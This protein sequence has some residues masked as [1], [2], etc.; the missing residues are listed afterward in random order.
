MIY[1]NIIY[2]VYYKQW[3]ASHLT[4]PVIFDPIPG[5]HF[6]CLLIIILIFTD[7]VICVSIINNRIN[8]II[9]IH[10][11]TA[12]TILRAHSYTLA[13]VAA[14]VVL[15]GRHVTVWDPIPSRLEQLHVSLRLMT[16]RSKQNLEIFFFFFS[17]FFFMKCCFYFVLVK[18][19]FMVSSNFC[20][21]YHLLVKSK[22]L[23]LHV[24]TVY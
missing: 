7:T 14:K 21:R 5:I 22:I 19:D 8:H 20:R 9:L 2:I 3:T 18:C 24:D 6:Y 23:L 11:F 17:F 10:V 12:S 4:S 16:W 13:Y 1:F 15:A